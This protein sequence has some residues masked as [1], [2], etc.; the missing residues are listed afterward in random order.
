MTYLV[1]GASGF[2]G[3]NLVELLL[4]RGETVVAFSLTPIP[5]AACDTLGALPGRLIEVTGD[6]DDYARLEGAVRDHRV[7]RIAHLAAI[8]LGASVDP[9]RT[10]RVL[11]VNSVSS[12]ALLHLAH[13]HGVRRLLLPSSSAA[14]GDALYAG[15][16]ISEATVCRPTSLYG[17][18]KLLNERLAAYGRAALG[19]D[20]VAP[21]LTAV[22]GPWE[23]ATGVRETLSPPFQLARAAARGEGAVIAHA[24]G[25]RDW[26][27]AR[28]ATRALA[29]LLD[30]PRLG[31]LVYN[32]GVAEGWRLADLCRRLAAA[33]PAFTWRQAAAGETPSIAYHAPLDRPRS[34][35]GIARLAA[36]LGYAPSFTA[37]GALDDYVAWAV[38]HRAFLMA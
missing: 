35:L 6:I 11:D 33:F 12:V 23:H 17:I 7:E 5:A 20:V 21:R 24:G 32:I 30:A 8:T 38:G 4:G 27:Y 25:D 26:V 16:P 18:T 37:E 2:V 1:T 10:A 28:D 34:P 31:H 29:L 36:D 9:A 3:L 14:Y 22:F 15:Q 19:L 13:A